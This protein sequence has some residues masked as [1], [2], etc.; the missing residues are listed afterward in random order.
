MSVCLSSCL[1]VCPP[2]HVGV[3][4]ASDWLL[5][6]SWTAALACIH[7]CPA[8]ALCALHVFL[9][10][11]A[12]IFL[13]SVI[14]ACPAFA[15][16]ALPSSCSPAFALCALH[17]FLHS[18]VSSVCTVCTSSSSYIQCFSSSKRGAH[19]ILPFFIK[20]GRHAA[21]AAVVQNCT[22][23]CCS[24]SCRRNSRTSATADNISEDITEY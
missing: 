6:T 9:H 24:S 5:R 10:S 3:L 18:S 15:L 21:E 20:Q 7:A 16:C 22:R 14:P 11:R 1:S 19:S 8:F 4:P 17:V 13:H 2:G 12:S 23:R